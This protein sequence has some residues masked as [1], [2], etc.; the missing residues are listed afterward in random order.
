MQAS[1]ESVATLSVN[2]LIIGV[3]KTATAVVN[4]AVFSSGM[5]LDQSEKQKRNNIFHLFKV[6]SPRRILHHILKASFYA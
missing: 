1:M 5:Q 3:K 6:I 2:V 4:R